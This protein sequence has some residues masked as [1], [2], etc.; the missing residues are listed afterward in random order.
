MNPPELPPKRPCWPTPEQY[1]EIR[2]IVIP[3]LCSKGATEEEA[4][5]CLH[6]ALLELMENGQADGRPPKQQNSY[7]IQRAV[8]RYLSSKQTR[9]FTI[10]SLSIEQQEDSQDRLDKASYETARARHYKDEPE[11]SFECREAEE[12]ILSLLDDEDREVLLGIAA[13]ETGEETANRLGKTRAWVYQRRSRLKKLLI[14]SLDDW[15]LP[16]PRGSV[17]QK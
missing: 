16:Q 7:V 8:W 6:I 4:L 2:R 12:E 14:G 1:E 13:G 11:F 3:I 17:S 5:D 15:T 9:E 10:Q